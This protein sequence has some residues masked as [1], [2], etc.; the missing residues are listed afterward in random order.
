MLVRKITEISNPR[1]LT[2][3]QDRGVTL[4]PDVRVVQVIS[5]RRLQVAISWR[6]ARQGLRLAGP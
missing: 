4:R 3:S 1:Q 5:L 6:A 2:L